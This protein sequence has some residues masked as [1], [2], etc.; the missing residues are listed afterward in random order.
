MT[1]RQQQALKTFMGGPYQVTGY[2]PIQ[3]RY[4]AEVAAAIVGGISGESGVDLNATVNRINA[5]HGSGGIAEWRLD[6]KTDMEAFVR[7]AGRSEIDL[8]AQCWYILY[9]L[10]N[11]ER[12]AALDV[13][14]RNPGDRTITT[15]CWDFVRA[16]E[17]PNMAVAHMDDMRVPQAIK[18][19][20]TYKATAG[21]TTA[22]GV[23]VGTGAAAV[24]A[25]NMGAP[26]AVVLT[27]MVIALG[28]A[29]VNLNPPKLKDD[30]AVPV[31]PAIPLPPALSTRDDY[32][33]KKTALKTALADFDAAQKA[34]K[35]ELDAS[36]A[37]LVDDPTVQ[38]TV[39]H[40]A[41]I[42][43]AAIASAKP[44]GTTT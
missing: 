9:E 33:A 43:P 31:P 29:W 36:A 22:G 42:V 12:F 15:L 11:V 23:A 5:D 1:I 6:R 18:A 35:A 41:P 17:V 21:A 14:L 34:Y 16:Y 37:E 38:M 32:R 7:A 40:A 4:S 19:Y 13:V 27:L 28:N 30:T 20:N 39:D 2:K 44:E 8:E 25:Y 26:A 10:E 3:G 24:A